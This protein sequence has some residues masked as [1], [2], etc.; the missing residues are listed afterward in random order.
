MSLNRT[1]EFRAPMLGDSVG[2]YLIEERVEA[3]ARNVAGVTTVIMEID[4]A[5]VSDTRR[6]RPTAIRVI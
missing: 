1:I 6:Q 4:V 2:R 5:N 3:V